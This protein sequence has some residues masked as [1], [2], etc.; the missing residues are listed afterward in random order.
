MLNKYS[1]CGDVSISHTYVKYC[2]TV[3][4]KC[5]QFIVH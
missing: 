5:M 4:L 1:D 2:Q 3:Y